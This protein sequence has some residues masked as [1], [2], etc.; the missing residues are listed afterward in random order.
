MEGSESSMNRIGRT[1][2]TVWGYLTGAVGRY[3]RSDVTNA[4]EQDAHVGQDATVNVNQS[5]RAL[6]ENEEQKDRDE[7]KACSQSERPQSGGKVR[8]AAV[9]WEKGNI[10]KEDTSKRT[11]KGVVWSTDLEEDAETKAEEQ[12]HSEE[13]LDNNREVVRTSD[14]TEKNQQ[15]H[16]VTPTD[17]SQDFGASTSAAEDVDHERSESI[18]AEHTVNEKEAK[19]HKYTEKKLEHRNELHSEAEE[20]VR[21]ISVEKAVEPM[22]DAN[23]KI[24][25][26]MRNKRITENKDKASIS[27]TEAD[28][29]SQLS[30]SGRE[31]GDLLK[32]PSH[33][34][35]EVEEATENKATQREATDV[36]IE[37]T[38]PEIVGTAEY[39]QHEVY[40]QLKESKSAETSKDKIEF[41]EGGAE[42]EAGQIENAEIHREPELMETMPSERPEQDPHSVIKQS[43]QGIVEMTENKFGVEFIESEAAENVD[44]HESKLDGAQ[45]EF[46]EG[47]VMHEC[48][49]LDER[50]ACERENEETPEKGLDLSTETVKIKTSQMPEP[51]M[52]QDEAAQQFSES[53]ALEIDEL[54]KSKWDEPQNEFTE[55][56]FEPACELTGKAENEEMHD[57]EPELIS[58]TTE[59]KPSPE[60]DMIS[61]IRELKQDEVDQQFSESK[62]DG[63]A[64]TCKLKLHETESEVTKGIVQADC[65]LLQEHVKEQVEYKETHEKEPEVFTKMIENKTPGSD[66]ISILMERKQGAGEVVK[67]GEDQQ[68]NEDKAAEI[69]DAQE[70][71]QEDTEIELIVGIVKSEC[72]L[73]EELMDSPKESEEV[74]EKEPEPIFKSI[75]FGSAP[76]IGK[77]LINESEVSKQGTVEITKDRDQQFSE[78]TADGTAQNFELNLE[79]TQNKITEGRVDLWLTES[80]SAEN[81]VSCE[82]L[83]DGAQIE[84]IS[85]IVTECERLEETKDSPME[86]K[87]AHE[88]EPESLFRSIKNG[89]APTPEQ[90]LVNELEDLEEG[91]VGMVKEGQPIADEQLGNLVDAEVDDQLDV[92]HTEPNEIRCIK[93]EV[94][95]ECEL[96]EEPASALMENAKMCEK[97]PELGHKKGFVLKVTFEEESVTVET[98]LPAAKDQTG[99]V[100]QHK[101]DIKACKCELL[102]EHV[103]GQVE[104]KEMHEKEPE[105]FTKMIE[106]KTPGS[107]TIS[108]LMERKQGAG[109]VV[110]DEEDQQFN[111]AK[112][113]EIDDAHESKQEDTE[114]ELIA[115]IV[116]SEC[117]LL[118]ELMDSPKES[119]EVY[120]KEP[121][122]I[123]KSIE[124]GSA[125]TIGKKLINESEISKQRTVEITKD[126]AKQI[127]ESTA[128]GTAQTF[129]LNLEETQ[130]KITGGRVDTE[131]ELLEEHVEEQV[132][133]EEIH[134]KE[135]EDF[136]KMIENKT[137]GSE[138][139]SILTERTKRAGEVVKDGEDQQFNEDKAAEIDDAHE[140]KQEDT[141]IELIAGIVKSECELLAELMDS[142][143]ESKEVY[144]KEP[145]PFIK[146]IKNRSEPESDLW[147]T[148]SKAPEIDVCESQL[149][150]AQIE[151]IAGTVKNECELLEEAKELLMGVE[152]AHKKE[153]ESLFR[154]I[155]NGSAPTPEQEPVNELE[156]SEEGT[157]GMVKEGQPIAGEQLGDLVDAEVDDQLDVRHTEPNETLCIKEEVETECELVEEPGSALMEN[158]EMCE[159]EPELSHKKGFVLKVTFEEESVAVET[160]LSAAT[161]QTG[162]VGQHKEDIKAEITLETEVEKID[163][164]A[165][166][167]TGLETV[168]MV[169]KQHDESVAAGPGNQSEIVETTF[170]FH[171]YLKEE[172]AADEDVKKSAKRS[173]CEQSIAREEAAGQ[174]TMDHS[175]ER[176]DSL[177]EKP[178]DGNVN[179]FDFGLFEAPINEMQREA[180]ESSSAGGETADKCVEQMPNPLSQELHNTE[181]S[182]ATHVDL[183]TERTTFSEKK[184]EVLETHTEL[185]AVS[186]CTTTEIKCEQ[187]ESAS[188]TPS[189]TLEP[190]APVPTMSESPLNRGEGISQETETE[191]R[192]TQFGESRILIQSECGS[193]AVKTLD[194]PRDSQKERVELNMVEMQGDPQKDTEDSDEIKIVLL[195]EIMAVTTSQ[196]VVEEVK[197]ELTQETQERLSLLLS[198]TDEQTKTKEEE[199][200]LRSVETSWTNSAVSQTYSEFSNHGLEDGTKSEVKA[201]DIESE[202]TKSVTTVIQNVK[203]ESTEGDKDIKADDGEAE[204]GNKTIQERSRPGLKRGLE[205]DEEETSLASKGWAATDLLL[206]QVSSLD[207]TV[208]KSKIAVKNP[209]V[210][211]PKDPRTLIN[212]VSVEPLVPTCP[213]QPRPLR[214]GPGERLP[215]PQKVIGFKLPGLG[216]GLPVLRKTEAGKKM[217]DEGDAES[218]SA[219]KSDTPT[220][221]KE[222]CVK[223][224]QPVNK[225]KW[226]PPR[227]PGMG[228]PLM[229]SELKSKLKKPGK[230]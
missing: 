2:W 127:S 214:K 190:D 75:E 86:I 192:E 196:G 153:P 147:L 150:G 181:D 104:N 221:P 83:L 165:H 227:H 161:D 167:I 144:E 92:L 78:S 200:D 43:K 76:T 141:E 21:D 135:P 34:E 56:K 5:Y 96:V 162:Q 199:T 197:S 31:S 145:E 54:R 160:Y 15:E 110:K 33:K 123:F 10:P 24:K 90:E 94:E 62:P 48:E 36:N 89:S 179:D 180:R 185:P 215:V 159:K 151:I 46:T 65:D 32:A 189:L 88:K 4:E 19:S 9:Q 28:L 26:E 35:L 8:T 170:K 225:P 13:T 230:D 176:Q 201:M 210:R 204:V 45:I 3:L 30:C 42:M 203:C 173:L 143:K 85:G 73:L 11:C 64:E 74:Y 57:K 168:E 80:K 116:K 137:P 163:H 158:A 93:E 195:D 108:I 129:E 194:M 95:T 109:E 98:D 12:R 41:R 17:G 229:M 1:I 79:E 166:D 136:T 140:S 37:E 184:V 117:E 87:V 134:E 130:N 115:G 157:V 217:R 103:E 213:L 146:S 142:P 128:D 219:Q 82:A 7:S 202:V 152:V 191:T 68:F 61:V 53:T 50:I 27:Q 71:K 52:K 132:E 20:N 209:H 111:E 125:P 187:L 149:A 124:F 44:A 40:P 60:T 207:C 38:M 212:M 25:D 112:A 29:F 55:G 121:E 49:L 18:I 138:T 224:E 67:D 178:V 106:N 72:E 70:S 220:E 66:T 120:E 51:E 226:T 211:P 131:R 183:A 69:D 101:E 59:N 105:A 91:T 118:D 222:V 100:G 126:G 113:A 6:K 114:I 63:T 148:E 156:E 102:E 208:Q 172:V 107:D 47:L 223:Q 198:E 16:P 175:T 84:L 97:E 177:Q 119:E 206:Q 174:E 155:K 216:P 122:P 23:E 164:T 14:F 77:E 182:V 228:N 171:K 218:V 205:K 193:A 133:D 58:Q 22:K 139:I 169:I 99:Q 186:N 188:K 81:D 39:R 154:S